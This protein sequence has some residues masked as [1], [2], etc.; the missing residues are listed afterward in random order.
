MTSPHAAMPFDR[1]LLIHTR[2]DVST[3]AAPPRGPVVMR[4]QLKKH[5]RL[6]LLDANPWLSDDDLPGSQ[7]L[8]KRRRADG[9]APPAD[10]ADANA[11]DLPEDDSDDG[12]GHEPAA[13]GA[14]VAAVGEED[15]AAHADDNGAA[16]LAEVAEPL[17]SSQKFDVYYHDTGLL[18]CFTFTPSCG[19]TG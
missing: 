7:M 4:H 12:D 14:A 9:A 10:T 18:A 11:Y 13:G 19:V 8:S 6:D 2:H 16:A 15:F 17:K 3:P 1:F 5:I